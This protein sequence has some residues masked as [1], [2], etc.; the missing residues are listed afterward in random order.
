[1]TAA[2]E[3]PHEG[4]AAETAARLARSLGGRL[5]PAAPCPDT[6]IDVCRHAPPETT[7]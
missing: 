1:M 6:A 5:D 3:I 7:P 4:A 2:W